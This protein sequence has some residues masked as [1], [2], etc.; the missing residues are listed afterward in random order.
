[1]ALRKQHDDRRTDQ[2]SAH[3]PILLQHDLLTR[4]DARQGVRTTIGD[5]KAPYPLD[6]VNR[7]CRAER[8]NQQWVS[9]FIYVST[10]QGWLYVAFVI[11]VFARRIVGWQVSSSMRTDYVLDAL[12]Q[13]LYARQRKR[14]NGRASLGSGM[15]HPSSKCQTCIEGADAREACPA[16][17]F[18]VLLRRKDGQLLADCRRRCPCLLRIDSR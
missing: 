13:A 10:W 12:E 4:G 15:R 3:L 5:T 11:D 16:H 17:E 1:V 18:F 2:E 9:D 8:P 7:Q 14:P 6:R